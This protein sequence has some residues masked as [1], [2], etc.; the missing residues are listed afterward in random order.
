MI[1]NRTAGSPSTFIIP[2][3]DDQGQPLV[4][5]AARWVLYDERGAVLASDTV[6]PFDP[7][8]AAATFVM[9]A[10]QLTVAEG[11]AS[12]GRELVVFA[13]TTDGEVELR[14]YFLLVANKPLALMFN[15]FITY[16]E[17]MALRMSF[18][19]TLTGWDANSPETRHASLIHA[20]QQ[21]LRLRLVTGRGS[22]VPL[23]SSYAGFGTGTDTNFSIARRAYLREMTIEAFDALPPAFLTAIKR[24]Q[25]IEADSLMGGNPV[26]A[27]RQSGIVSEKI[28]E[29][30]MFFQSKPYLNLPVARRTYEELQ[31]FIVLTVGI[32]R[33]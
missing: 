27:K 2:M 5:T 11:I 22:N 1:A 14:D 29:S 24:A 10:E 4:A 25:L 8:D 7:A 13:T 19:P 15:S 23:I 26:D 17:A 6:A 16:P 31:T 33:G 32:Q 12:A 20:H 3:T 9:T 30:S 18:G 28:G 21:L